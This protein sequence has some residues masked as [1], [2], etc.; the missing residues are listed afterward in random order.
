MTTATPTPLSLSRPSAPLP[1]AALVAARLLDLRQCFPKP[2]VDAVAVYE[3]AGLRAT[4]LAARAV[5]VEGPPLSDLDADDLVHAEDLMAGARAVLA[6]VGFL[7]VVVA[8]HG[9][10]KEPTLPQRPRGPHPQTAV[11]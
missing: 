5:S 9:K 8:E 7:H 4:E 10:A 1:S 6:D 3:A 2:V 11:A